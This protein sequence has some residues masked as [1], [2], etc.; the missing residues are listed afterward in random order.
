VWDEEATTWVHAARLAF[1][2]GGK[3]DEKMFARGFVGAV[4]L[5][6]WLSAAGV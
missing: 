3:L 6:G 4:T 1:A 5:P 2:L